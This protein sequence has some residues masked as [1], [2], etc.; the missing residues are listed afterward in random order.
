MNRL[1]IIGNGFDLAHGLKTSYSD[2]I[3]TYISSSINT[4][5]DK[6]EIEDPLL[7]IKNKYRGHSTNWGN[8]RSLPETALNDF[9]VARNHEYITVKIKSNFFLKT[10]N[11]IDTLNWVDLENEYFDDLMFYKAANG[12]NFDAVKKLNIEFEFIKNELEKYLSSFQSEK[13]IPV[14]N[15]ISKIFC[16]P[17]KG[18]DVVTISIQDLTID[19]LLILNF[20]YTSTLEQYCRQCSTKLPTEINYIHGQLNSESNPL[21]FGFGDEYNKQYLEFEEFRNKELLQ[22]IKSFGYFKASNYHNLIRFI[23]AADFQVYVMGHSLGLSDRTML[24]QIFEHERC[25]SIKI[26]YYQKSATENDYT[27]KTF[28]ISSHFTDKGIMR[29]K[30]VPFN[31]SSSMPQPGSYPK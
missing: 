6:Q 4:F 26:F 13:G 9:N 8:K 31:L 18:R 24:R 11:K 7:E 25:K 16:E 29:K 15:E 17:V 12:F 14:T 27:E 19:K 21:I 5:F 23:D 30:I 1:I 2:F 3:R 22:H 10:L 20:N 28:D